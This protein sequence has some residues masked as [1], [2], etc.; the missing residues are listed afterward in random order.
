M[1]ALGVTRDLGAHDAGGCSHCPLRREYDRFACP[2]FSRLQA[3]TCLG[4]R[5]GML[6]ARFLRSQRTT[7]NIFFANNLNCRARANKSRFPVA[8]RPPFAH[9]QAMNTHS[10]SRRRLW[11]LPPPGWPFPLGGLPL[12]AAPRPI[13]M[14]PIPST[15]EAIPVLG[16]GTWICLQCRQQLSSARRTGQGSPASLLRSRRAYGRLLADVR[17][18]RGRNGI[19]PQASARSLTAFFSATKIW[20]S[21][22]AEGVVQ[23]QASERLWGRSQFDL[24]QVHNL[25]NWE[26]HLARLKEWKVSGRIRYLRDHDHTRAASQ[27][28]RRRHADRAIGLRAAHLQHPRSRGGRSPAAAGCGSRPGSNC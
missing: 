5:A 13:A 25:L 11:R 22:D 18:R 15:G 17:I 27:R 23:M 16:M 4:N 21:S 2:R 20:T 24:Q 14:C 12:A 28:L 7:G 8:A 10:L 3:G 19:L 6:N 9:S 1:N 26:F